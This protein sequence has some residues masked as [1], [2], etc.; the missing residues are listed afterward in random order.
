MKYYRLISIIAMALSPLRDL[1]QLTEE[2]AISKFQDFYS[3]PS[4]KNF[5]CATELHC[6]LY[7]SNDENIVP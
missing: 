4:S 2:D 1:F 6:Q 3:I 5:V 7:D